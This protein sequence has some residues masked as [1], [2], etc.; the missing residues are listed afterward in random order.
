LCLAYLLFFAPFFSVVWVPD[1]NILAEGDGTQ[2]AQGMADK[3]IAS[4][5]DFVPEEWGLPKYK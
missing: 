3:I 5:E 1:P 4:L 2:A